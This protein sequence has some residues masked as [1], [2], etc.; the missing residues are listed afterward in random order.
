MVRV[1]QPKG[2][3][4]PSIRKCRH[5]GGCTC[6]RG[7]GSGTGRPA[8]A[9]EPPQRASARAPCSIAGQPQRPPGGARRT[10]AWKPGL[11]SVRRR[12]TP[13]AELRAD[14]SAGAVGASQSRRRGSPRPRS[15]RGTSATCY[16]TTVRAAGRL[17]AWTA[18]LG[19][20][21]GT[22]GEVRSVAE[23][24]G[25]PVRGGRWRV[26][27]PR[28]AAGRPWRGGARL[29]TATRGRRV[30]AHRAEA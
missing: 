11:R 12:G 15:R 8:G 27:S 3:A 2:Q 22:H 14:R 19:G 16:G 29:A 1:P 21:G 26:V 25:E 5:G 4:M 6:P 23:R 24:R 18:T 13:S 30:D 20:S 28:A 7:A 9:G 10:A 17:M